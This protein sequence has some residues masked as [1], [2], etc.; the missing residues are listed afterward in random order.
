VVKP[1]DE[2]EVEVLGIDKEKKRL[3]LKRVPSEAELAAAEGEKEAR[4]AANREK[5][6]QAKERKA[7]AK[8]KPHERLK[9]GQVVEATVDRIESYGLFVKIQGGGRGMIHV[10]ESGTPK[11]ADLEKE[12]PPGTKIKAVVL[13]ISLEPAPR[14]RLSRAAVEKVEAGQTVEAYAAEKALL[15]AANR[16]AREAHGPR[17]PRPRR[18]PRPA[19][20]GAVEAKAGE[21]RERRGPRKPPREGLTPS[22]PKPGGL[23]TLGDLFKAKLAQ[24]KP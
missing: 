6:Q 4:R 8:L 11:G 2:I 14:I 15:A 16:P 7:L 19:G 21:P 17:G 1:G 23:G 22:K 10:S 5:R 24:K 13:E 3:S 9:V 18:P 20:D 12:L